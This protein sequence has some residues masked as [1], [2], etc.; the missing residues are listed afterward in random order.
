MNW[1]AGVSEA[2]WHSLSE[3][4]VIGGIG[5]AIVLGIYLLLRT[6]R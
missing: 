6:V 2:H 1:R 5:L 3:L 4:L